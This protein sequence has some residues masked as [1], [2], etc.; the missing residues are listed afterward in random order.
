VVVSI[1]AEHRVPGT[2]D[3]L[4]LDSC[5]VLNVVHVT[6]LCRQHNICCFWWPP[7][8]SAGT[9]FSK[10]VNEQHHDDHAL[11]WDSATGQAVPAGAQSDSQFAFYW[12][13]HADGTARVV[14]EM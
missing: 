9:N 6:R 12:Q 3:C 8:P 4:A 13:T 2:F 14:E 1:C 11:N 5:A 10:L 7:A